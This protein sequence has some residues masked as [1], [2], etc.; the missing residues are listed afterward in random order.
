MA[1]KSCTNSRSCT[2]VSNNTS[3]QAAAAQSVLGTTTQ[4]HSSN[5]KS[6]CID[7][8]KIYDSAKDKECIEDLRVYLGPEGQEFIDNASNIRSKCAE[9]LWAS[10]DVSD[11]AFNRGYYSINI[12]YYFRLCF[13]A[14]VMG[15]ARE[16]CGIAVYDKQVI[17]YGGEGNV[18]IFTSNEVSDDICA[19]LPPSAFTQSVANNPKVQLE[20]APPIVLNVKLADRNWGCGCCC[21]SMDQIPENLCQSCGC[22]PIPEDMGAKCLYVTLGLFSLIK[23]E[24]PVSLLIEKAEYCIPS[25][26]SSVLSDTTSD[27]CEIFRNMA[28]PTCD[29]YTAAPG[30]ISSGIAGGEQCTDTVPPL[31]SVLGTTT[32]TGNTNTCGCG[33]NH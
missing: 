22:T 32:N 2:T 25:R 18:S 23:I 20:V 10:I 33:C 27:P 9:I 13:E 5:D 26:E 19:S 29:F 3:L 12:R 16:F 30:A 6:T 24:R 4:N 15:R 21:C 8:N 31:S 7:V 17:M 14:C 1:D 11:V 28:F